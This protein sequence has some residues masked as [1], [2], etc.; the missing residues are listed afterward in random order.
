VI[1][2]ATVFEFLAAFVA[3]DAILGVLP[4]DGGLKT[5]ATKSRTGDGE[6]SLA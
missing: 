6:A 5:A 1:F 4:N 2:Q 3:A